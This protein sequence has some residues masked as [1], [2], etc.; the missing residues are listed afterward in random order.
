M[1]EYLFSLRSQTPPYIWVKQR[2]L[3]GMVGPVGGPIT[4]HNNKKYVPVVEL[5]LKM[6]II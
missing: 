5:L 1:S 4:K 6:K 3:H 2:D